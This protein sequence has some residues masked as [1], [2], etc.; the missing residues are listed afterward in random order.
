MITALNIEFGLHPHQEG[1]SIYHLPGP[2]TPTD[3]AN[4]IDFTSGFIHA[5]L[6]QK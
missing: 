2:G 4:I 5:G 6:V 3:L 1:L